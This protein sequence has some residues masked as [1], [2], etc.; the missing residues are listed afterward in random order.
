MPIVVSPIVLIQFVL[1]FLN[2]ILTIDMYNKSHCTDSNKICT[3]YVRF[4]KPEEDVE[5]Q[6]IKFNFKKSTPYCDPI[7]SKKTGG[8]MGK[9][10]VS[11]LIML[12]SLVLVIVS[13]SKP[14]QGT[15]EYVIN[16]LLGITNLIVSAF[17]FTIYD[18]CLGSM[19]CDVN[20]V[21]YVDGKGLISSCNKSVDMHGQAFG[22]YVTMILI[23]IA[24]IIIPVVIVA[25]N[26]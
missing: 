8:N 18:K 5:E 23:L 14:N 12:S 22:M 3:S 9:L 6:T 2:C 11:I 16:I 13:L 4:P 24:S 15:L 26:V 7:E 20:S 21:T 1:L 10:I 19:N 25:S 17:N